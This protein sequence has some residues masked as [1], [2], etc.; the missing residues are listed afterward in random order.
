MTEKV[1]DKHELTSIEKAFKTQ[2][3][4]KID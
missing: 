4:K 1:Y 3:E 2:S